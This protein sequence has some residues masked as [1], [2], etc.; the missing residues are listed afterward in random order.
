MFCV[1]CQENVVRNDLV[2]ML[3]YFHG[4]PDNYLR[5]QYR[6]DKA[7]PCPVCRVHFRLKRLTPF[8]FDLWLPFIPKHRLLS[9]TQDHNREQLSTENITAQAG[10]KYSETRYTIDTVVTGDGLTFCF[11]GLME[12]SRMFA[13]SSEGQMASGYFGIE[14]NKKLWPEYQLRVLMFLWF[15]FVVCAKDVARASLNYTR[16][17]G[18]RIIRLRKQPHSF[19]GTV[20]PNFLLGY[21]WSRRGSTPRWWG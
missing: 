7:A 17:T 20:H 15:S 6:P 18:A 3:P 21:P 16:T 14:W 10:T 9:R 5:V 4:Y 8:E 1:V 12:Q 13:Y 19:R 2:I 11:S